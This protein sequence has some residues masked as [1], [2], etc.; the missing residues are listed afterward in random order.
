MGLYRRPFCA[1][2]EG[3]NHGDPKAPAFFVT[4]SLV[5]TYKTASLSIKPRRSPHSWT[6]IGAHHAKPDE[7]TYPL[8]PFAHSLARKRSRLQVACVLLF[9]AFSS[10]CW[11]QEDCFNPDLSNDGNVGA[12]DLVML[13]SYYDM[14]WP[15]DTGFTCPTSVPHHGHDYG[16][17]QI[18]DQCWFAENCRHLPA[19]SPASA[20]EFV[21]HAF[22]LD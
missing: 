4:Y 15:L 22:V 18:G 12:A 14:A 19:V 16:V 7:M 9:L 21:P 3:V 5:N 13:L 11:G 6:A 2:T 8:M 1:S 20:Q 17:V 10:A